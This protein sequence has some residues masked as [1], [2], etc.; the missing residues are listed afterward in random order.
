MLRHKRLSK[1]IAKDTYFISDKSI[2]G[3]NCAHIFFGMTSTTLLVAAMK[4]ESEFSDVYVDF[5]RQNGIPSA[6]RRDHAKSEMSQRV[7]QIHCVT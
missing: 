6:L 1:V 7:R 2:D 3:Y 4:T 5:I